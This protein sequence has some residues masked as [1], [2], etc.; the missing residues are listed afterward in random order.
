M[1]AGLL[2][3][4][5]PL[6]TMA[7]QNINAPAA[8]TEQTETTG[9]VEGADGTENAGETESA[10]GAGDVEATEN[11]T[12]GTEA[13]SETTEPETEAGTEGSTEEETGTQATENTV[14]EE[15]S[16]PEETEDSDAGV[17]LL[18]DA[19]DFT[20]NV[21]DAAAKTTEIIGYTGSDT[22]VVIP[23]EIDGYTVTGIGDSA[24]YECS[25]LTSIE[26]PESVISL[27]VWQ[28]SQLHYTLI[29]VKKLNQ[30]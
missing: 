25:G 7:E 30:M 24:F 8:E 10:A 3:V 28:H 5:M 9:C 6:E 2:A 15:T 20:Y 17:M 27:L 4:G 11:V 14:T 19:A 1:L 23:E 29:Q 12:E 13:S 21:T 22:D 18:S 26:I 16:K